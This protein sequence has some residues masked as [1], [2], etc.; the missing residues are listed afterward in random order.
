MKT[1][2]DNEGGLPQSALLLA[3][4]ALALA[5]I[6]VS[7]RLESWVASPA[8]EWSGPARVECEHEGGGW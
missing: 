8:G 4:A 6:A 1:T 3:L 2:V 7:W 5:I